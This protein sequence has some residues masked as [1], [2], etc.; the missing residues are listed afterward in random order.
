MRED[1]L[2]NGPKNG[3]YN[4]LLLINEVVQLSEVL[5][6]IFAIQQIYPDSLRLMHLINKLD[7]SN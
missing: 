6:Y 4:E 5:L 1:K 2:K 3:C 7:Y